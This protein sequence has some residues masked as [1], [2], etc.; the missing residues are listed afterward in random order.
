VVCC[1]EGE[2]SQAIERGLAWLGKHFSVARNPNN[3]GWWLYYLYGLERV[4]RLSGRRFIGDHDWYREGAEVLV[5]EQDKYVGYWRGTGSVETNPLIGTAFSLLFLAKG[6]RP[7]VIA[8]SRHGDGTDW[9]LHAGGVPNL[10]RAIERQWQRDLTWQT[11]DLKV[12]TVEDLLESPVLFLSGRQSLE[13]SRQQRDV[14]R[15]YVEQGGFIFAEACDGDGCNGTAFDRSFRDLMKAIFPDSALRLLPADH[16][17]WYAEGKVNSKY[18]RPLYGV[19]AC[20]RT[21]VVYCPRNLSCFWELYAGD[22]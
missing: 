12:A 22:R 20:C 6:R 14:L 3:S 19:D 4:G 13:L 15:A 1:G 5:R 9:D 18:M 21:S 8:K 2:E 7:V 11:I 10:T 16:P 17:V